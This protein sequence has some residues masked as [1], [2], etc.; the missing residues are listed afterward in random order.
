MMIPDH[1]QVRLD[2]FQKMADMLQEGDEFKQ[3]LMIARKCFLDIYSI[4]LEMDYDSALG[5][6]ES[7]AMAH[8][9]YEKAVDVTAM[10]K[11]LR[12]FAGLQGMFE[13]VAGKQPWMRHVGTWAKTVFQSAMKPLA[14]STWNNIKQIR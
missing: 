6:A 14:D 8:P 10:E 9:D 4:A 11:C 3:D 5:L 2:R 7:M 1:L 12:K 13:D